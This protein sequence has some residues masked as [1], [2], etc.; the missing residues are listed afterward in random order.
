MSLSTAAVEAIARDVAEVAAHPD[1]ATRLRALAPRWTCLFDLL[2]RLTDDADRAE[3]RR[4]ME[5][6]C[7]PLWQRGLAEALPDDIHSAVETLMSALLLR[8]GGEE[9]EAHEG[10][11][12]I[13]AV[14][15]ST[16]LAEM[17]EDDA[18][19]AGRRGSDL[20]KGLRPLLSMLRRDEL[21]AAL[22]GNDTVRRYGEK[23]KD[24]AAAVILGGRTRD[25]TRL[26]HKLLSLMFTRENSDSDDVEAIWNK[27]SSSKSD[28]VEGRVS[29]L[30]AIADALFKGELWKSRLFFQILQHGLCNE[31]NFVRKRRSVQSPKWDQVAG[32]SLE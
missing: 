25:R 17:G 24:R 2:G 26:C 14:A 1:P 18:Q 3:R 21:R 5:R 27:L 31:D 20:G 16:A 22:K 15:A 7:V 29:I 13:F 30:S 6:V 8:E 32:N 9:D 4:V 19:A 23:I 12:E 28:S 10:M 11:V